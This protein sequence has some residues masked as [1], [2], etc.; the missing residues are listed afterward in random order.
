MEASYAVSW[1][2]FDGR[3]HTG[4]LDV[5]DTSMH[6]EGGNGGGPVVC[7]VP[8]E[9][10]DEVH[11]TRQLEER[12][13]GLPTLVVRRRSGGMLRVATIAAPGALADLAEQLLRQLP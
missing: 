12:L 9:D 11:V 3:E 7:D 1:Q 10:V 4:R 5:L 2:D 6:L 8:Y 13:R